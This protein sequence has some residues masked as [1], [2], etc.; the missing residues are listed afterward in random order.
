MAAFFPHRFSTKY[1]DDNT[2]LNYYDYRIRLSEDGRWISRG[3]M[4]EN[5]S[6]R[7]EGLPHPALFATNTP[8][9]SK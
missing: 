4:G 9:T 1:W 8:W 3:P 6:A 7:P 5:D 2:G